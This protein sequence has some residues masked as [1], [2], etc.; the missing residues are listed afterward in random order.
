[1][2]SSWQYLTDIA[3][4]PSPF[5]GG[6]PKSDI[7]NTSTLC[8]HF[9]ICFT[10]ELL[11]LTYTIYLFKMTE[12]KHCHLKSKL[13]VH[14]DN[15]HWQVTDCLKICKVQAKQVSYD[16]VHSPMSVYHA[17]IYVSWFMENTY[18]QNVSLITNQ[19]KWRLYYSNIK[20]MLFSV[21]QLATMFI[22]HT[23]TPI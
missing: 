20:L 21:I 16:T 15:W 10:G 7:S 6:R 22:T 17:T 2:C 14:F 23:H 11:S 5:R 8:P 13:C 19:G 9:K 4:S 3:C 1:M 18:W 12:H